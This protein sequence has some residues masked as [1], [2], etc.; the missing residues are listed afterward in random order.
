ME[1]DVDKAPGGA[2]SATKP[3]TFG[4]VSDDFNFGAPAVELLVSLLVTFCSPFCEGFVMR[5][6]FVDA[7][8]AIGVFVR[9]FVSHEGPQS[10]FRIAGLRN[11]KQR[12]NRVKA[13][14]SW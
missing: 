3:P 11:P 12:R 4:S 7:G 14:G 6:P 5:D 13:L 1:P 10:I 9:L 2:T 8:G